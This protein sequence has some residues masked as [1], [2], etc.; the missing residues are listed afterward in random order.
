VICAEG[1]S[2]LALQYVQEQLGGAMV[3]EFAEPTAAAV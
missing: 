2:K 3:Q 1:C